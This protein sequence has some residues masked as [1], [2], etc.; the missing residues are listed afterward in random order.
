MPRLLIA[1]IASSLVA[2]AALV[3]LVAATPTAARSQDAPYTAPPN[4][5][6]I[7]GLDEAV[8]LALQSHEAVASAR[9]RIHGARGSLRTAR[10]WSNPVVTYQVENAP[11]PGGSTAPGLDRETSAFAM[12]PLGPLYQRGSRIAR[13]TAEVRSAEA[14]LDESRRSL[15]LTTA[16]RFFRVAS[17]QVSV[18]STSDVRLW[19]DSLVSY[20]RIRV[21]EGA[22]AAADLIRLEVEQGRATVDEAMAEIDLIRESAELSVLL[23]LGSG[24]VRTVFQDSAGADRIDFQP[25]DTLIAL[26]LANRPDVVAGKA[27]VAAASASV[28]VERTALIRDFGAMAGIKAM[29]GAKSLMA[30]VSLPLPILDRNSGEIQRADAER[31]IAILEEQLIERRVASEV[32]AAY[33][34]AGS[35]LSLRI[36]I[37]DTLL[38]KAEEG[39]RIA[40]AAYREGAIPLGQVIEASRA[41]ADARESHYRT[42]FGLKQSVLELEAAIGSERFTERFTERRALGS[43]SDVTTANRAANR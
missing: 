13:A 28:R 4:P 15:A 16:S 12:L 40:E 19:L 20:T 22:T 1:Q 38:K 37:G 36:R 43:T 6:R 10:T 21:R 26:G 7:V 14:D 41:L 39:R 18:E 31:R 30:G 33:N 24:S 25:L 17:A 35:L 29:D 5:S 42:V 2:L 11:L 9:V 23:G 27:R 3:A 8:R 34:N 32:T